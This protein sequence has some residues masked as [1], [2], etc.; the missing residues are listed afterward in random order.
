MGKTSLLD[1]VRSRAAARG[2]MIAGDGGVL[3]VNPGTSEQAFRH[4][5]ITSFEQTE[6]TGLDHARREA[7]LSTSSSGERLDPFVDELAR[8]SPVLLTIDDYRASAIFAAWFEESFL[9]AVRASRA[10]LVVVIAPSD[11]GRAL[12][13][14]ATHPIELRPLDDEVVRSVLLGLELDPPLTGDELEEYVSE[15]ATPLML[16]SLVRVL[17]L[18]SRNDEGTV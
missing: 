3:N 2:W 8:L 9:R 17:A 18:A 14:L 12:D 15:V 11:T 10:P 4:A 13:H 1:A 5:V 6:N 7:A 16:D